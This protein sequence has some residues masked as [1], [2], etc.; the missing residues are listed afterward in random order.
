MAL[1]GLFGV[2]VVLKTLGPISDPDSFW[3]IAAGTLVR[4]QH[5]FVVASDP[6]SA[7]AAR[8]WILNQWM[9]EVM[10]S[11]ANDVAGLPGVAWLHAAVA[12]LVTATIWLT[13]RARASILTATL[14]TAVVF[15]SLA[16]SISPRPQMATFAFLAITVHFWLRT[17][18]DLRPRW[19]LIAL[20]WLWACSHGLWFLG[21]AV[22]AVVIGGLLLDRRVGLRG[23]IRLAVIPLGC[24]LAAALTPVGPAL[25]TSPFQ[26]AGVTKYIS[27]WQPTPILELSSIAMLALI[28]LP[29]VRMAR[30]SHAGSWV[31]IL[32]LGSALVLGLMQTRTVGVAAI[33]AAPAA[34]EALHKLSGLRREAGTRPEV[35]FGAVA[36]LAALMMAAAVA[37]AIA[38]Q[39]GRGPNGLNTQL[40]ALPAGTVVCNDMTI[41]GW[42][43][44]RH[45]DLKVV[46]DTRVEIYTPRFIEDYRGAMA[47][48]PGWQAFV[49]RTTCSVAL[50][51]EKAPFVHVLKQQHWQVLVTTDGM[52][53]LGKPGN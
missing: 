28:A 33:M 43:I 2:F 45:P 39:P 19:W 15:V 42:L 27:E 17:A 52:V 40:D 46:F 8:P 48:S 53:L 16:G 12:L 49:E 35:L 34:A 26:V 32:L 51:E 20:S 36:G 4:Q 21:A 44:Y 22:G 31:T 24:V 29:V 3:H 10:M 37:P 1:P 38:A 11:W 41:G 9:P 23:A 5:Q 6:W 18:R 13:C 30:G 47:G 25:L 7:T 14:V 50:L